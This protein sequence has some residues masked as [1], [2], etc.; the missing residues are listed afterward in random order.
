MLEFKVPLYSPAAMRVFSTGIPR[1]FRWRRSVVPAPPKDRGLMLAVI[2]SCESD[3][4]FLTRPWSSHACSRAAP[5]GHTSA[6]DLSHRILAIQQ[7]HGSSSR[8]VHARH[9]LRQRSLPPFFSFVSAPESLV[10][11][12][13][14]WQVGLLRLWS[15]VRMHDSAFYFVLTFHLRFCGSGNCTSNCGALAEC[16]P[17]AATENVTCPLNVCCSQ[18]GFCGTTTDF[19]GIG[20]LTVSTCGVDFRFW[21]G[22]AT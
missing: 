2:I 22:L 8:V 21:E 15:F 10:G 1:S 12:L 16:G 13:L 17:Y 9:S 11:R 19:C 18:Y 4:V 14:Q 3:L 20:E 5:G 7:R 6:I